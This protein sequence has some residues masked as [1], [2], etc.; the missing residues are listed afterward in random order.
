MKQTH[1]QKSVCRFAALALVVLLLLGSF[2]IVAFADPAVTITRLEWQNTEDLVYGSANNVAV[3]AYDA[4]GNSYADLYS[5]SYPAGYGNA[6]V[7]YT[8]TATLSDPSFDEAADLVHT[9]NVTIAPKEYGVTMENVTVAGD[10]YKQYMITVT[11]VDAEGNEMPA[12]LRARDITYT[13]DGKAFNGAVAYG[14]YQI[15]ATLPTGNYVFYKDGNPVS[16]LTATLTINREKEVLMVEVKD[17]EPYYIFLTAD[18]GKDGTKIGLSQGVTATVSSATNLKAPEGTKYMQAFNFQVLNA[19]E[20]ETFTLVISRS[21]AILQDNNQEINPKTSVYIYDASGTPVTAVSKGYLVSATESS[22]KISGISAADGNLTIAIAPQYSGG[23]LPIGWIIAIIIIVIV[24]L[25]VFFFF[26]GRKVDHSYQ[27][28]PEPQPAPEPEP[29][30]EPKTVPAFAPVPVPEPSD[31]DPTQPAMRG[32]VYIDVVKNPEEY[33][34]MLMKEEAGEGVVVY[35]YRKSNMAKLALADPKIG[36][37]YSTI[38]N[39]LLRFQGVKARKS[40]NY[41]AFNQ[42][43]N[44][45]AKIIPNGKTL[46]LYLAIDPKTLEGTKYGAIDV[47][48]K[49][50]FEVTPSLMKV[51]GDRKLKF[52]LELIEKVCGEILGLKPTDKPDVNYAPENQT[53]EKLFQ[54]GQIRKL[55]ALA[56]LNQEAPTEEAP[57]EAPVEAPVEEAPKTEE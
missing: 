8:L 26:M 2:S 5:V 39:A 43:R 36:E 46:Y 12:D 33:G 22:V 15:T 32:L 1:S 3:V 13:V 31:A 45:I 34:R 57:A 38:K 17:G 35:R 30:P 19:A 7:E 9:K 11:G 53:A 18:P 50:K 23:G 54:S 4:D 25:L 37:Y 21:D 29:E 10:G 47:S 55:A 49:K 24:A 41:E 42:G 48:D 51:R 14:T 52:A 20:G 16:Q 44:Q 56:P 6:N 28:E 40:W 27:K